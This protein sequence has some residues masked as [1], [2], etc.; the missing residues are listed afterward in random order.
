MQGVGA[1]EARVLSA[2]YQ[3]STTTQTPTQTPTQ[4]LTQTHTLS[5][6]RKRQTVL[7][8]L[9][10]TVLSVHTAYSVQST[11]QYILGGQWTS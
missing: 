4:T 9:Y 6:S 10:A 7:Q 5:L 8:T 2:L 3:Q 11:V 1:D